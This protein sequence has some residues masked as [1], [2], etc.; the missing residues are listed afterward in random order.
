M[1]ERAVFLFQELG[2]FETGDAI[3]LRIVEDGL[4]REFR[5]LESDVAVEMGAGKIR[6]KLEF[7]SGERDREVEHRPLQDHRAGKNEPLESGR[8]LEEAVREI[9]GRGLEP[10]PG[11]FVSGLAE[12]IER[13]YAGLLEIG[14]R[15]DNLRGP[16]VPS[17][18]PHVVKCA[19]LMPVHAAPAP[20]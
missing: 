8:V 5:G 12:P 9:R 1:A 19:R 20:V 4:A 11:L 17:L 6:V 10:D 15:L 18:A 16:L 3:E 7:R 14:L 13:K 2:T